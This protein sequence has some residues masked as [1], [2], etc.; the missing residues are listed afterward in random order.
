MQPGCQTLTHAHTLVINVNIHTVS[1]SNEDSGRNLLCVEN[2]DGTLIA[3]LESYGL[4][5]DA[6]QLPHQE[7][8]QPEK[9]LS[10]VQL[11]NFVLFIF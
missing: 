3:R 4:R 5:S 8:M 1:H 7:V 10:R 9:M 11:Y 2:G 6:K